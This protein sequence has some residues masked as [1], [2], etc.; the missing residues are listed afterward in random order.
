MFCHRGPRPQTRPVQA[1]LTE[2]PQVA[3]AGP[4]EAAGDTGGTEPKRDR[5]RLRTGFVLPTGQAHQH[6]PK[7][8]GIRRPRDL[9]PFVRGQRDLSVRDPIAHARDRDGQLLIGE[10]DRARLL[11]P[12]DHA[13]ASIRPAVPGAGQGGHL[14]LQ[15]L[16]NGMQ[17]QRNQGLDQRHRAVDL[18]GRHHG[19]LRRRPSIAPLALSLNPDYSFPEAAPFLWCGV[20]V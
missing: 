12:A 8:A 9:Q 15:L 1:P 19:A 7:Q 11:P 16:T 14:G 3:G 18:L 6:L 13:G 20:V 10:V 5:Y 17:P 2:G 4:Y